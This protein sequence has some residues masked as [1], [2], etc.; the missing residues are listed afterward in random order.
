[1]KLETD[2]GRNKQDLTEN[3]LMRFRHAHWLWF[4][5]FRQNKTELDEND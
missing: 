5:K 3:D 2:N 1:M 4:Y